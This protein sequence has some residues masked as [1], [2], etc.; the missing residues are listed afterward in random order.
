MFNILQFYLSGYSIY[1]SGL[2]VRCRSS[3]QQIEDNIFKS[4]YN[5][6]QYFNSVNSVKIEI[7]DR[8]I[9]GNFYKYR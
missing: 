2:S 3:A 1:I 6:S 8:G 7:S 9:Y 5:S 4:S